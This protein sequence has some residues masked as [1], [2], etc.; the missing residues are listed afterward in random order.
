MAEL[1]DHYF[2]VRLSHVDG[3]RMGSRP[4]AGVGW[5]RTPWAA[6]PLCIQAVNC[7]MSLANSDLLARPSFVHAR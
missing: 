2:E 6:T 3:K 1:T 5:Q 7:A 4:A